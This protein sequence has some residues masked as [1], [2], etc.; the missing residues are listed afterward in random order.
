MTAQLKAVAFSNMMLSETE[1]EDYEELS[2]DRGFL[3]A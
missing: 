3:F 1:V 2:M